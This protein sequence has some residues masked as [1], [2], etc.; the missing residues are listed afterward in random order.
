MYRRDTEILFPSRVIP[1]LR[2]LRGKT[3]RELVEQVE[4]TEPG[5]VDDLA[6]TLMMIRIDGCVTCHADCYRAMRGCTSCAQLAIARYKGSDADLVK[7]FRRAKS[8]VECYLLRGVPA[9]A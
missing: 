7:Q 4:A 6:F 9:E 5:S 3:W 8:D 1:A 2:S